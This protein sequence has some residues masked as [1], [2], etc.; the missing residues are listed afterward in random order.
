MKHTTIR[1]AL[2]D[3]DDDG[4]GFLSRHEI[5]Q[6]R[7]LLWQGWCEVGARLSSSSLLAGVALNRVCEWLLVSYG[8]RLAAA[9]AALCM[10]LPATMMWGAVV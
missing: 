5:K 4:S 1:A 2:K 3:I 10:R 8:R 6:A 9:W 7:L